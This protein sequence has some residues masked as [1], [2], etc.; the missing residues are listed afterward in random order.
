MIGA[1]PEH[2]MGINRSVLEHFQN[3]GVLEKSF[4]HYYLFCKPFDEKQLSFLML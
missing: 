4:G 1:V 2:V 3:R